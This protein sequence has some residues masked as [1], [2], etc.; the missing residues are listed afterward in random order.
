[1]PVHSNKHF[2]KNSSPKCT[3]YFCPVLW[4]VRLKSLKSMDQAPG[5]FDQCFSSPPTNFHPT[6]QPATLLILAEL[7]PVDD[8]NDKTTPSQV[9]ALLRL[10]RPAPADPLQILKAPPPSVTL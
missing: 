7:Q 3:H 9:S 5:L 2:A 8:D 4:S 1:M 6:N 10:L